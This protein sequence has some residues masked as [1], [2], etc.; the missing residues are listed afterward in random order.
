MIFLG[1][2]NMPRS[3]WKTALL[4]IALILSLVA[5]VMGLAPD[6]IYVSGIYLD[7]VLM[8]LAVFLI[9]IVLLTKKP[10]K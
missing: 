3:G 4:A 5:I 6:L 7:V 1:G 9:S 10:K 8:G 2:D